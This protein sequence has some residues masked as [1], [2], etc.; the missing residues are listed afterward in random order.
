MIRIHL[1]DHG[2]DM[3]IRHTL[4]SGIDIQVW[5]NNLLPNKIWLIIIVRTEDGDTYMY[6][7]SYF[8]NTI[9]INSLSKLKL[10]NLAGDG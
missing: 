10:R 2:C 7:I 8:Q 3:H 6:K 4:K 1:A 5:S 9:Q